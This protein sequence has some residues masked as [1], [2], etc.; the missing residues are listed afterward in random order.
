LAGPEVGDYLAVLFHHVAQGEFS[1]ADHNLAR[2]NDR[3]SMSASDE[4]FQL[5]E[6]L[7]QASGTSI[8]SDF[9]S[10]AVSNECTSQ[11]LKLQLLSQP[12]YL[13]K[14]QVKLL[15][16]AIVTSASSIRGRALSSG[17]RAKQKLRC[18]CSFNDTLPQF[19]SRC[20]GYHSPHTS[21]S[22]RSIR[23]QRAF[24]TLEYLGLHS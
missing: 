16:N 17:A 8:L 15:A 6:L 21:N 10:F 7:D 23:I 12:R 11:A 22:S 14:Q 20:C 19:A 3:F 5:L 2:W 13:R 18:G 24:R 4:L 9:V 1:R